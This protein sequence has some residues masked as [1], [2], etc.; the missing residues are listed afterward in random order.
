MTT[1]ER[2]L[3]DITDLH[4]RIDYLFAPN[5]TGFGK[6]FRAILQHAENDAKDFAWQTATEMIAVVSELLGIMEQTIEDDA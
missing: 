5:D 1:T 4:T 2:I 6:G 3:D